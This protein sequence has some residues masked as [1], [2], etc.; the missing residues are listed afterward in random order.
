MI[1]CKYII[2]A[3]VNKN[4]LQNVEETGSIFLRSLRAMEGISNPRGTGFLIAFDFETTEERDQFV[5]RAF[6]NGVLCNPT[7]TRSIRL[8]PTLSFT[9]QDTANAIKIIRRSL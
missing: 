8:R 1:R 7:G 4:L 9:K 6:E 2:S 3:V 5:S